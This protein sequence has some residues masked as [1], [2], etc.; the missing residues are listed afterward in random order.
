MINQA[1]C[2]DEVHGSEK[3][4]DGSIMSTIDHDF[5]SECLVDLAFESG[6][7]FNKVICGNGRDLVFLG[8][9]FQVGGVD[10]DEVCI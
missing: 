9:V 8:I 4:A 5:G 3:Q 10:I 6:K 1:L 2:I 7:S